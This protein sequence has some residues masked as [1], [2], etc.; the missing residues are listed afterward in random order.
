MLAL[1]LQMLDSP[2]DQSEFEKLYRTHR[3]LMYFMFSTI[4]SE[5]KMPSARLFFALHSAFPEFWKSGR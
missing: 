4:T 5:R 3:D 1:Y 2:E